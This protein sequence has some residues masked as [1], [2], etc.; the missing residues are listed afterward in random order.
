[1]NARLGLLATTALAALLVACASDAAAPVTAPSA[2][3]ATTEAPAQIDSTASAPS[4][5]VSTT[6]RA[7]FGDVECKR[8]ADTL[9]EFTAAITDASAAPFVAE[10]LAALETQVAAARDVASADLAAD[11]D[12]LLSTLTTVAAQIHA[13]AWD[14]ASTEALPDAL[15]TAFEQARTPD[16]AAAV[17]RTGAWFGASCEVCEL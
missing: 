3:I 15:G 11:L 1:M 7:A 17:R 16:F 8:A 9:G 10:R 4:V 5:A 13:A 14:P 2:A 6:T 12:L